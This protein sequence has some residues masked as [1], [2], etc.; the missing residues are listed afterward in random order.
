VAAVIAAVALVA[1]AAVTTGLAWAGAEDSPRAAAVRPVTGPSGEPPAA[2]W[3]AVLAAVDRARS[4][5]FAAADPALL[6]DVYAAD[7]PALRRDRAVL[8]RLADAGLHADGLRLRATR[9]VQT[10]RSGDRVWLAVTDLLPPYRL[11]DAGDA[12]V[13]RRPGRGERS[14]TVV[15]E[16]QQGEGQWRVYDVLRR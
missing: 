1:A 4:R 13:E 9:V 14:W 6:R 12:V 15:L 10:S 5:A 8:Q 16:R 2:D 7:A 11:R 3:P